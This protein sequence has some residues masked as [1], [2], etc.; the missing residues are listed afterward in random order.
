[1]LTA[2]Q[3]GV[4]RDSAEK[5]LDPITEYLLDD[6]AKRVAAAGQ[7][8]GTASYQVWRLQELGLSQRQIKKEVAKRLKI[9]LKETEKLLTQVAKTGYNFDMSRFPTK[10]G[11]PFSANSSLQQ[12]LQATVQL[13]KEDLTN[14][15]QTIGF[16]GPDGKCRKLTDAYNQ[17]CDF[18]F[19]KA[20][21]G[22]QNYWS[23][24][25]EATKNLADQGIRVIDYESG[26]HVSI[27]AAVR[28]NI[29]GGAGLMQEQISQ[30]NHDELG[31][32]GWEISA[33]A[34][35][36][37][38]HEPYQ[39]KQYT[40]SEYYSLNN[41]L[42]RRIGT[43]NCGHS[44]SPIILGVNDPQ[45]TA[46]ELEQFRKENEEG[47][48][49]GGKHYT[50]YEATQRQRKYERKI[51][52]QRHK[53]LVAEG[54][55]DKEQLQTAQIKMVRLQEEYVRFSKDAKL[56][57][58]H[59]RMEV[60]GFNWKHA[61]AAEKGYK[62]RVE[63]VGEAAAT[64]NWHSISVAGGKTDTKY[65]R[66]SYNHQSGENPADEANQRINSNVRNTNPAFNSGNPG[67]K[68]NCQRCVAAYEMR[69]RGYDVIAKPAVVNEDGKLSTTDP[70]Y[71]AW[72]KIFDGARFEFHSGYDGGKASIISQMD[73]WGDG[74]VA[75]VR[76]IWDASDAHVFVAQRVN[77]V[78]RFVDPQ[79]GNLNCEN[80]FTTAILGATMIA[81]IDNLVP[82][83]LIEKC[84]KNRGGKQ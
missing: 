64:Q 22:G 76:V 72:K 41:S 42:V 4:L 53:I 47:I 45:Y 55:N 75:E 9:S 8:T 62:Q 12:I 65:R 48:T 82:S 1:M 84:I 38:D 5:L 49:I 6:I 18:A 35:S 59:A 27:E 28:R 13:A 81:R 19:Q 43:L 36:A 24:I 57:L 56:P 77:G 33:H 14:I 70:L 54:L 11:I 67:Y 52:K 63:E 31:C 21:T 73:K 80:Y 78:V 17:A 26:T 23:A 20:S 60:A 32:D 37:P 83:A 44:A 68:Q 61:K 58:Q 66:I 29:M 25:R 16:V 3:I 40:D 10:H 30:L 15:T 39:G 74:A 71:S 51:R 46:E 34:A 7:F 50:L 79:N 2:E 69:R